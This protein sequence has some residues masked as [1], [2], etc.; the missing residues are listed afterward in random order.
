MANGHHVLL[1]PW[2]PN[3]S[4]PGDSLQLALHSF[5]SLRKRLLRDETLHP[6]CNDVINSYIGDNYARLISTDELDVSWLTWTLPQFPIINP[7]K[8]NVRI[9]YDCTAKHKGVVLNDIQMQGPDLINSLVGVLRR[10]RKKAIALTFDI[11]CMF[12]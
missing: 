1:L 10:F 3:L 8:P 7:R 12:H 4:Y 11:E 2:R 6:K 5:G 9:V